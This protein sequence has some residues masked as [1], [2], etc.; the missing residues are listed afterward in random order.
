MMSLISVRQDAA[1]VILYGFL[2]QQ[3]AALERAMG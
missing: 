1:V 2:P 3:A